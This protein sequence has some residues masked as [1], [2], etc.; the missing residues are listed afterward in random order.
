M[1]INE[2]I[3]EK[4]NAGQHGHRRLRAFIAERSMR[5][6]FAP[7]P[8]GCR[9]YGSRIT[10]WCIFLAVA[11]CALLTPRALADNRIEGQKSKA[12]PAL[13]VFERRLHMVHLGDKSNDIWHSAYDGRSWTSNKL[14]GTVTSDGPILGGRII[15]GT[16]VASRGTPALA[17][18]GGSLHMVHLGQSSKRIWHMTH[19]GSSWRYGTYRRVRGPLDRGFIL[20]KAPPALAAFG[21]GLHM[22]RL[23]GSNTLIHSTLSQVARATRSLKTPSR[24][25]KPVQRKSSVRRHIG[26]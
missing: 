26:R 25:I 14:I 4:V 12:T 18:A 9:S 7:S 1:K 19:D 23:G 10:A 2:K 6:A 5:P 13:A 3:N 24:S 15:T 22:V 8:P 16:V 21:R 20:S 11:L 17:V